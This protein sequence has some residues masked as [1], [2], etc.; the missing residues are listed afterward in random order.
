MAFAVVEFEVD[1]TIEVVRTE[2]L[3][4]Q[5]TTYFPPT[6]EYP[7][8]LK[9]KDLQTIG[10]WKK[11]TIKTLGLFGDLR[12]AKEYTEL[13]SGFASS[14]DERQL[15][16]QKQLKREHPL[17]SHGMVDLRDMVKE[18]KENTNNNQYEFHVYEIQES[19]NTRKLD[20]TEERIQ[21]EIEEVLDNRYEEM[22]DFVEKITEGHVD[23]NHNDAG[24][25][26]IKQYLQKICRDISEL[27]H[28]IFEIKEQMKLKNN[29]SSFDFP[30]IQNLEELNIFCSRLTNDESFNCSLVDKLKKKS[31]PRNFHSELNGKIYMIISSIFNE[32]YLNSLTWGTK[33]GNENSTTTAL[34]NFPPIFDLIQ[35]I[36][37]GG[38]FTTEQIRKAIQSVMKNHFKK[39]EIKTMH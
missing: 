36:L 13:N 15:K 22:T 18:I 35:N 5:S 21:F 2:W 8:A 14:S 28:E 1:S 23:E 12:S 27:K 26:E 17:A 39:K 34:V 37:E 6:I 9:S 29:K 19:R 24:L 30:K 32:K 38:N 16:V 20:E 25:M 31:G 33:N 10:S 3:I 7:K 4:N 11:Y